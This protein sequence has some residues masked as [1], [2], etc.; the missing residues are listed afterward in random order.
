MSDKDFKY[1]DNP[2]LLAMVFSIDMDIENE[3]LKLIEKQKQH[4]N[5]K[6]YVCKKSFEAYFPTT[7][8]CSDCELNNRSNV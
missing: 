1:I 2:E 4:T 5:R 3:R 6:C 8:K 7:R